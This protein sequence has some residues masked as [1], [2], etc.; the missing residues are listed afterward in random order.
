MKSKPKAMGRFWSWMEGIFSWVL[1]SIC[2][3]GKKVVYNPMRIMFDRITDIWTGDKEWKAPFEYLR[4]FEDNNHD[5]IPELPEKYGK[6]LGRIVGEPSLNPVNLVRNS[7]WVTWA[8]IGILAFG[9]CI[10][11]AVIGFVRKK[12]NK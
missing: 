10:V 12:F 8:A 6:K 9:L 5:G 7:T 2:W 3:P 11:L 1:F 4:S